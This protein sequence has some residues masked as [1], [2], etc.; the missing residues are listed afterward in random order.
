MYQYLANFIKQVFLAY[1]SNK[2]EFRTPIGL[3]LKHLKYIVFHKVQ[4]RTYILNSLIEEGFTPPP[5]RTWDNFFID[6]TYLLGGSSAGEKKFAP[7]A[8]IN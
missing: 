1:G 4:D 5:G 8:S 7:T 6:S 2:S 3:S